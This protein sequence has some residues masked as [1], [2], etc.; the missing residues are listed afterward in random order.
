[1]IGAGGK[2]AQIPCIAEPHASVASGPACA[3]LPAMQF[4]ATLGN[5]LLA[6]MLSSALVRSVLDSLPDAMVIIDSSGNILFANHQVAALFGYAS[7]E[8]VGGPVEVLLPERFRQRHVGHRKGY[9]SNVRVR[10]MGAGLELYATR[11][12]GTEFPVEIS[13]SPIT[14][15][16]DML[17]AAAIRDV[18]ERKRVQQALEDARRDAER[19]NIAKSR[20]LATAS[21]DLRQ[22]LQALGLLNGALRR[23]VTDADCRDVLEQQDQAVDA[24]SRLLNALLDISKLE[25]GAIKLELTDFEVAAPFEEMRREFGSVAASKGLSFSVDTPHE[26]VHSD[27]A[28][29]GQLLRNL[30]SNAIKY[31]PEGRVELHCTRRGDVIDIEV[32]DSGVGIPADQ[33]PLIFDEFYQVGVNPNSSRDG[34]GLG[35]SIVQRIARL[36]GIAINVESQPGKGSVFSF[37][38][39]AARALESSI[40]VTAP[41]FQ[42]MLTQGGG[43]EILL[44]EDEPGVRNAM[45]ML[46]KLEGYRVT[47]A[48]SHEEALAQ[49]RDRKDF[50]LVVTDYH[51]DGGRTGTEVITAARAA[52]GGSVKAILV[53]GDT[54]SAVRE[55]QG[56]AGLRITSKPINSDELLALV[57]DLLAA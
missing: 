40:P 8:I 31:T 56:D 33:L 13:L 55:I 14:Q 1:L 47:V 42:Q 50:D 30:L 44:V 24:M 4:S 57:R 23:M 20:F 9:T 6:S 37:R 34:Y 2:G 53:T 48:S 46:L 39:P 35:L 54:S 16:S 10:P 19:A 38:L 3:H 27:P 15:G 29:V 25:S 5:Q 52:L 22:P 17:V 45:R 21:H 51:L 32:R 49:L 36:L 41:S 43:A 12:D 11:K 7:S 26:C 28:L 18:S